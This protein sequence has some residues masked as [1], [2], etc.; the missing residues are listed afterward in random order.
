MR[1]RLALTPAAVTDRASGSHRSENGE[2]LMD[3]VAISTPSEAGWR[4]RIVNYA[5][6]T[7]EESHGRFATIKSAVTEGVQRLHELNLTDLS[8]PTPYHST[9]HLRGR[10]PKSN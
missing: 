10:W 7:V 1:P 5:G 6:E 8:R 4:W 2:T 3:V 9:S